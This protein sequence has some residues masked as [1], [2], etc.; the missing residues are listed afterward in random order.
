M[1]QNDPRLP[2]ASD[3]I[4]ERCGAVGTFPG[5]RLHRVLRDIVHYALVTAAHEAPHHVG[6][7]APETDHADLH[8]HLRRRCIPARTPAGS[9]KTAE[10]A[11]STRAPAST[12]RGTVAGWMPPSTSSSHAG[13][14]LF[15]LRSLPPARE[16]QP[17]AGAERDAACRACGRRLPRE[18]RGRMGRSNGAGAQRFLPR[19]GAASVVGAWEPEPA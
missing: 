12:T 9:S 19:I 18:V 7:H 15:G 1:S 6:A 3:E 11:T 2:E 5:E 8:A 17:L 10:P 13:R 4:V 14:T 16:Y